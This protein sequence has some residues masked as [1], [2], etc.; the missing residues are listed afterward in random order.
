MYYNLGSLILGFAAWILGYVGLRTDG[1]KSRFQFSSFTCCCSALMLQF[2]EIKRRC[3]LNDWSAVDDTIG[4]ITFAALVLIA[5]TVL[6]NLLS[7]RRNKEE[8][9]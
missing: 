6:L 3:A 9:L 7:E 4:G 8:F 2:L 1:R 5:V